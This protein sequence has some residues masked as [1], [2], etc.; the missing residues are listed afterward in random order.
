LR[1]QLAAA[2]FMNNTDELINGIA[3]IFNYRVS[4]G[5]AIQD[6]ADI[7]GK[8]IQEAK[9]INTVNVYLSDPNNVSEMVASLTQDERFVLVQY[10]NLYTSLQQNNTQ[11]YQQILNNMMMASIG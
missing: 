11:Q 6:I 8:Q 7:Y 1:A 3:Q 5:Q 10:L 9:L 2:R 4:N